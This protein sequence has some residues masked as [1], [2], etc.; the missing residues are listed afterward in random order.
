VLEHY[1]DCPVSW[2]SDICFHELSHANENNTVNNSADKNSSVY[3]TLSVNNATSR[4]INYSTSGWA[5]ADSVGGKQDSRLSHGWKAIENERLNR[6]RNNKYFITSEYH[7][8]STETACTILL[9]RILASSLWWECARRSQQQHV[10]C[11][12]KYSSS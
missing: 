1:T 8:F 10:A 3:N 6:T 9:R 2:I 12:R 5:E 11:K 7:I 4:S